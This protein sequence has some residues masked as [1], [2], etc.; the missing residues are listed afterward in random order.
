L[1]QPKQIGTR[2]LIDEARVSGDK[3]SYRLLEKTVCCRIGI[4]ARIDEP[5]P[6]SLFIEVIVALSTGNSE[7]H[8]PSLQKTLSLLK[9]LQNEGYKLT[10]QDDNRISCEKTISPLEISQ[11]YARA[12]L[13]TTQLARKSKK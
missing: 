9:A 10:F 3:E 1:N 8:L 4:G 11:E 13:M 12:K 5:A 7:V 2:S 6:P